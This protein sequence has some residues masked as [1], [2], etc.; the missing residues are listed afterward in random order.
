LTKTWRELWLK[1]L[2]KKTKNRLDTSLFFVYAISGAG[3]FL[4]LQ[5]AVIKSSVDEVAEPMQ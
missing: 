3:S 4:R 1:Q 2:S 5:A